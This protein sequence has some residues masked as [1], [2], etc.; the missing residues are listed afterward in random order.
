MHTKNY[1]VFRVESDRSGYRKR[2]GSVNAET[3]ATAE[4]HATVFFACPEGCSLVVAESA[5]GVGEK[6]AAVIRTMN[7]IISQSDGVE[8]GAN[9]PRLKSWGTW[10]ELSEIPSI[11]PHLP[12]ITA[13]PMLLESLERIANI[14]PAFPNDRGS[15]VTAHEAIK[16][17]ARSA[18]AA[19][20][21]EGVTEKRPDPVERPYTERDLENDFWNIIHRKA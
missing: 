15:Y 21:G 3:Q 18:I 4:H 9:E 2:V 19:A 16:A 17:I 13:A 14:K 12:L 11:I 20:R 5:Q 10:G 1:E 7:S 8:F 6:A